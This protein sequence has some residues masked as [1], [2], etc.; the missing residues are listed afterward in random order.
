MKYKID[1]IITNEQIDVAARMTTLQTILQIIGANPTILRE[2]RTRKI[3]YK[4]I[5]L[6][7]FSPVDFGIEEPVGVEEM[8]VGQ[9]AERGGSIARP[10]PQMGTQ[11]AITQTRI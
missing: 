6:A 7:G 4:L 1:I 11:Q 8:M 5:D 3:F 10:M 2:P 9:V